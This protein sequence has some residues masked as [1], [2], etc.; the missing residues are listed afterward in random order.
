MTCAIPGP[1]RGCTESRRTSSANGAGQNWPDY[2]RARPI[3]AYPAEEGL[4]EENVA[5]LAVNRPLVAALAGLRA[6]DRDVLLLVAWA[7]LTY[8]EV[9][10]AL[11]IPV[12]T[13]RSR[14]NRARSK[15]RTQ[16]EGTGE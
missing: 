15:V 1:G 16:L 4:V 2:A 11:G 7:E 13:V 14:L 10:R 3:G 9:A 6:G 5:T 12:G 8:E